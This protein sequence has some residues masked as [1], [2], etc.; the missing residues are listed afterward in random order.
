MDITIIAFYLVAVAFFVIAAFDFFYPIIYPLLPIPTNNVVAP[1][2]WAIAFL[3]I[4]DL[5]PT[6][7]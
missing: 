1:S 4:E 6:L 3:D 2:E 5:E 7:S